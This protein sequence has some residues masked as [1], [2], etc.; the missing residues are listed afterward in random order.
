MRFTT[1]DQKEQIVTTL[2]LEERDGAVVLIA[3]YR[4]NVQ[5]LMK[6]EEGSFRRVYLGSSAEEMGIRTVTRGGDLVLV[7]E[8]LP[9][10]YL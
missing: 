5:T 1:K 10:E 3:E 8:E 4:D 2:K 6:F 9:A 7:I